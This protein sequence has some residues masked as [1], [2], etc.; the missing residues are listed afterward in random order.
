MGGTTG[1]H[2]VLPPC[3]SRVTQ[4]CVQLALECPQGWGLHSPPGQHS[5]CS[6][7]SQEGISPSGSG[8]CGCDDPLG[9]LTST[10]SSK[11][12]M[13]PWIPLAPG[14]GQGSGLP[15]GASRWQSLP[16][17]RSAPLHPAPSHMCSSEHPQVLLALQLGIHPRPQLQQ[18]ELPAAPKPRIWGVPR[19]GRSPG[20]LREAWGGFLGRQGWHPPLPCTIPSL[21]EFNLK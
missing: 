13:I 6:G 3:W 2:L 15:V 1:G 16:R 4:E 19:R 11:L 12:P 17:Q 14:A 20:A 9:S 8:G 21:S 10:S 18:L 7:P 5:Q